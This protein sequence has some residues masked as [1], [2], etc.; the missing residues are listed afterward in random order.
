M[1]LVGFS[2]HIPKIQKLLQNFFSGKELKKSINPDQANAY[3]AAVQADILWGEQSENVQDM[4]LLDVTL[5]LGTETASGVM[6]VFIKHS[7]IISTKQ[8]QTSTTYSDNQPGMLIL[9][10]EEHTV[11][12]AE[13]YKAE[14]ES[15][16]DKV[17][18]KNSTVSYAF[19][20]KESVEDERVQGK[21]NDEDKQK[22]LDKCN[23]IISWL[24]KDQTAEKKEFEHQQEEL[25]KVC[26]PIVTK[27]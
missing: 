1:V 17:S 19:N 27:L 24:D 9:V 23:E 15:Q 3:G 20:L 12:E 10:Y 5:S 25:E 2:T 7:T 26:N 4:L 11:Q 8:T 6:K 16:R 22:I 18:S 21:I 14:D 13:K